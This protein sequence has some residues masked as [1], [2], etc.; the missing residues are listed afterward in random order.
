MVAKERNICTINK[1]VK[2]L[3]HKLEMQQEE[4]GGY[5]RKRFKRIIIP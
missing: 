3:I 4:S 5:A 1:W 2:G